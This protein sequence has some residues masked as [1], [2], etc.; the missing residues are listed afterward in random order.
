MTLT[1]D[2]KTLCR[3][4]V[5]A[6]AAWILHAQYAGAQDKVPAAFQG[7][8]VPASGNCQSPAR[9]RVTE[10][11]MTLINGKDSAVYGDIAIAHSFFVQDYQG[12]SVV[13]MP[14]FNSGNPPFTV[15]FNA[16]EK[17]DVTKVEIYTEMKGPQNAQ[18]KAIQTAAKKLADRFP[19][20]KIP[21]KKCPADKT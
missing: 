12:I 9:F 13:A 16:D 7:D 1:L 14:D 19:L 11:K 5:T 21:L 20:N 6:I 4:L 8:W 17:K 3:A 15:Y 10:D 2:R 18:V